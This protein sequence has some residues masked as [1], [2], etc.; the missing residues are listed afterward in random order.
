MMSDIDSVKDMEKKSSA[1]TLSDMEMFIFPDLIYSLMLANIMSPILWRWKS[2]PWFKDIERKGDV[3]K[4]NRLKQFIM[5]HYSFNLDLDTWGLTTKE[6]ELAR[7]QG[8][9]DT[10]TLSQSNALFGYE[11]DKYYFDIDIRRHFGLDKYE[12]NVIP[13]WKTET[14]EA[15]TAFSRRQGYQTGAGECVSLAALYAA[16]LFV[17]L[18]I[19]LKDIYMMA[20]PLHSQNFVDIGDGVITNNRRIVTQNMWFNGTALSG[21]ARRSMEHE[22]ITLVAHESGTIHIMYPEATISAD[23]YRQFKSKLSNFLSTPLTPEMLGNFLRQSVESHKCFL[24]RREINGMELYV[25]LA[26]AFEYERDSNFKVTD[27]TLP[28]LLA[29]MDQEEF[30]ERSCEKC[31]VL[32]DLQAYLAANPVDIHQQ[33]DVAR[34]RESFTTTCMNSEKTVRNLIDFCH[35]IPRM[36]EEAEKTFYVDQA[37]LGITPL[38]TREQIIAQ[39]ESI[40][41]T[42]EY[43]RLAFYAFRDLGRTEAAPFLKAAVERNPVCIDKSARECPDEASL[44]AHAV[45]L[46]SESIYEE[47]GRLAQ[48]DEVWNFGTGDGLEKAIML[49]V[50]LHAR[51]QQVY[52]VESSAGEAVLTDADGSR[53][54]SLATAKIIGETK[55]TI[56]PTI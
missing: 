30:T 4:I 41:E 42:N 6:K 10:E 38:M 33:E 35:T 1:I 19:P 54:T 56:G 11:G 55:L 13:Y 40:R 8:L 46:S 9:V 45:A 50:I 20:T 49:G 5:D 36:P 15:M 44:I 43:C 48:P 26:R 21:Q 18:G 28:K 25:P 23:A 31:I 16:S 29:E 34:L 52:T 17:V 2:D 14:I 24:V 7:F 51:N 3:A 22:R 27:S 37:P 47:P 32:N 39:V 53:V 12:G